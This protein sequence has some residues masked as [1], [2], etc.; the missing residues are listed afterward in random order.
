MATKIDRRGV[1]AGTRLSPWLGQRHR[2]RV[3]A[4]AVG[5]G[6]TVCVAATVVAVELATPSSVIYA[7]VNPTTKAMTQSTKSASC[8]NGGSKIHWNQTGPQGPSGVSGLFGPGSDGDV[9]ITA[10]TL[11]RRDMYYNNLTIT[12]TLTPGSFR[13]FVRNTLTAQ[14]LSIS[15][16]GPDGA[17]NAAAASLPFE[18]LGGDGIGGGGPGNSVKGGD[19]IDSLGGSGGGFNSPDQGGGAFPIPPEQG[20][21]GVVTTLPYALTGRTVTGQA[22]TGGAGGAGDSG[23]NDGG[24]AGG[25]VIL[26]AAKQIVVVGAATIQ[27]RGGAA[28]CGV[29]GAGGGGVIIVVSTQAQPTNLLLDVSG[30]T[31]TNGVPGHPGTAVWVNVA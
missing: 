6:L 12:S 10:P 31:S 8:P 30:G 3:I 25:G 20:G 9:T 16:N 24:G 1:P 19:A 23:G 14:S 11:L 28:P 27:A 26:V 2:P 21:P 7:C 29:A 4:V 17:C 18:V 15:Y 22:I 13:I 5:V